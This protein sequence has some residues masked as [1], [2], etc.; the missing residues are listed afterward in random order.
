M[1]PNQLER[2]IAFSSWMRHNMG[3][4]GYLKMLD[5]KASHFL[6]VLNFATLNLVSA[7]EDLHIFGVRLRHA[8]HYMSSLDAALCS[9]EHMWNPTALS[10]NVHGHTRALQGGTRQTSLAK[11]PVSISCKNKCL[12]IPKHTNNARRGISDH[13]K[14]CHLPLRKML[15]LLFF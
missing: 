11:Y 13:H 5:I 1:L 10:A 8:S 2:H 6:V 3:L 12:N 9:P 15:D 7:V 14:Q 4:I